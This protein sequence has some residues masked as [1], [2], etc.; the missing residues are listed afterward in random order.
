MSVTCLRKT[1][2]GNLS[3]HGARERLLARRVGNLTRLMRGR[4]ATVSQL[5]RRGRSVL[6]M[7]AVTSEDSERTRRVSDWLLGGAARNVKTMPRVVA[8]TAVF[9][10]I[11]RPPSSAVRRSKLFVNR[12]EI[13]IVVSKFLVRDD[14]SP[15]GKL[16]FGTLRKKERI[17]LGKRGV[18]LRYRG[19]VL[20]VF[21]GNWPRYRRQFIA[22]G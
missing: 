7:S 6:A 21:G 4:H 16:K 11:L 14:T 20:N 15:L 18:G 10:K 17:E 12:F 8:N 1:G 2:S 19:H 5:A 22:V 13:D 9:T 3:I